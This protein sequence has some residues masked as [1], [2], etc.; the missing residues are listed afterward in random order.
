MATTA[1]TPAMN[2][3]RQVLAT[4]QPGAPANVNT[5]VIAHAALQA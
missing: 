2:E 5:N 4:P 1:A 3:L